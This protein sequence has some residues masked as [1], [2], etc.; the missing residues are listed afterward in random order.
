MKRLKDF[1]LEK[2]Q[3]VSE[4]GDS[5]SFTPQELFEHL[6]IQKRGKVDLSD[7]VAHIM[8]FAN[9]PEYLTKIAESFNDTQ[10]RYVNGD[11][12]LD[13]IFQKLEEEKT[14]VPT[15]HIQEGKNSHSDE[16]L[17]AVLIMRRKSVRQFPNGQ[18]VA[19]YYVDKLNKYITVPYQDMQWTEETII[20][21]LSKSVRSN[22]RVV[23]EHLDGSSSEITPKMAENIIDLYKEINETNK[24]KMLD[25]LEASA[26]HF[27]TI[28][29]FSKE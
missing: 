29:K 19:L 6:D 17:P 24:Q 26:Q 23:I 25:M 13:S 2:E 5:F 10:K 1:L 7:Y 28:A 22:S 11:K 21:K 3:L 9:H 15:E 4:A 14:L 27:Q 16:D 12:Q 18:R 8:F 20:D